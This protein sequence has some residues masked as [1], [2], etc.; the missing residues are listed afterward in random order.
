MFAKSL[1]VT[2]ALAVSVSASTAYAESESM[3]ELTFSEML[4]APVKFGQA[5]EIVTKT[6][7]GQIVEIILDE[8][9]GRPVYL[10][11]LATKTSLTDLTISATDGAV[12][13]TSIQTAASPEIMER[14]SEVEIEDAIEFSKMMGDISAWAVFDAIDDLDHDACK[15]DRN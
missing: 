10:A 12:L 7:E 9:D 6:A 8:F 11:T 14:L 3:V 2:T 4:D 13:A 1:A 5:V 15:A